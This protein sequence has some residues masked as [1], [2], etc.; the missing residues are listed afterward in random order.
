MNILL[1]GAT[2]KMGRCIQV[3]VAEDENDEIVGSGDRSA[4]LIE[5]PHADVLIDFSRPAATLDALKLARQLGIPFVTGTTGLDLGQQE[6]L[7]AA[8]ADIPVCHAANFALGVHVLER[9]VREA[10][11]LLGDAFDIE[12]VETHH[13][14]KIDAPSGTALVLGR[15]A[16]E[17]RKL[18]PGRSIVANAQVGESGR[19]A[20]RIGIQSL[21]GGDVV[22]EH[23]VHFLGDGERLELTHRATDRSLFARGALTAARWLLGRAPGRYSLEQVVSGLAEQSGDPREPPER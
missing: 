16:A 11:S 1:N 2:G 13:R 5:P 15:A 7:N 10:A 3:L 18:D 9:L 23:G 21:R 8:A 19:T 12:I 14:H 6:Q 20:E 22:G 17:G 4:R